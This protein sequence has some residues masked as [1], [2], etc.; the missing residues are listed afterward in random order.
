MFKK[1]VLIV[2]LLN[3]VIFVS[4]AKSRPPSTRKTINAPLPVAPATATITASSGGIISIDCLRK[5]P[6]NAK[7]PVDFPVEIT[8]KKSN[9]FG[10]AKIIETLPLGFTATVI[11]AQGAKF[12]F[13]GQKVTFVWET[14]PPQNELKISYMVSIAPN[15]KGIQITEG[16]FYFIENDRTLKFVLPQTSVSIIDPAI[17]QVIASA[18]K[19]V[20]PVVETKPA[21]TS[22]SQLTKPKEEKKKGKTIAPSYSVAP[23]GN[24]TFRVQFMA[25]YEINVK[26][27]PVF[28]N[29]T[30]PV[31][32]FL[33]QG[34]IQY[35]VGPF[36]SYEE[37]LKKKEE[38]ELLGYTGSFMKAFKDKRRITIKEARSILETKFSLK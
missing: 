35:T 12:S 16:V 2:C 4:H 10:Y 36:Y 38:L 22:G 17:E 28:E 5:S 24:I 26:E 27:P 29:I 30:E 37:A 21:A 13:V 33:S 32:T 20:N 34:F 1:L 19:T 6:N 9:L 7:F 3:A 25:L 23:T 14:L 15:T 31:T 18:K 8:I 11:E